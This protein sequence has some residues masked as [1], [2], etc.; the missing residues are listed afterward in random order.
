MARYHVPPPPRAPTSPLLHLLPFGF[1]YD[2]P[3]PAPAPAST[4]QDPSHPVLMRMRQLLLSHSQVRA[5]VDAQ[6]AFGRTALFIAVRTY[7]RAC[8]RLC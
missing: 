7:V 2:A 6:D 4:P 3:A 5:T 1:Y 8:V